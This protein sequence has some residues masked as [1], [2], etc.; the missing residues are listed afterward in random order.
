MT[1][2]TL[3]E[4]FDEVAQYM[5]S[6]VELSAYDEQDAF[7][8]SYDGHGYYIEGSGRVGG[9]WYSDGDGYWTPREYYLK[10]GWGYLCILYTSPSPRD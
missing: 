1:T 4:I 6:R 8:F 7:S 10:N 5:C 2:K 9:D 3:D